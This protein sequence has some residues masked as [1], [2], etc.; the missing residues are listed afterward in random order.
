MMVY[1]YMQMQSYEE[2]C[3]VL[4]QAATGTARQVSVF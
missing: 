3:A 4:M 1:L 2:V